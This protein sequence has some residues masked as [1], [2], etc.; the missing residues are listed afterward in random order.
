MS[1]KHLTSAELSKLQHWIQASQNHPR[2]QGY[3]A[4]IS[5]MLHTGARMDEVAKA[6]L[7][8]I[9]FEDFTISLKGSKGSKDRQPSLPPSLVSQIQALMSVKQLQ[10]SDALMSLISRVYRKRLRY[11][12]T[13]SS[14][15]MIRRYWR[16]KRQQ[17][18]QDPAFDKGLHCLRHTVGVIAARTTKNI[19][20]V[21]GLMG[22]KSLD[23]TRHYMEAVSTAKTSK[24]VLGAL[25]GDTT[26]DEEE[27]TKLGVG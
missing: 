13:Q 9:D 7:S 15:E 27:T 5:I 8:D 26:E 20:A 17:I 10:G 1:R 6:V 16:Q 21:S 23:S 12:Q 25:S 11:L 24:A 19:V 18:F 3:A 2:D 4:I 22:H 14:K